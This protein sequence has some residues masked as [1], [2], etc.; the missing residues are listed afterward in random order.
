MILSSGTNLAGILVGRRVDPE[1]LVRTKGGCG[2]RVPLPIE[3]GAM[4]PPQ[5]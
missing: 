1:G 2:Q 5:K 3:R 4:P